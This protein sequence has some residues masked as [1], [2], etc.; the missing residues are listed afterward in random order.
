M[1]AKLLSEHR[2]SLFGLASIGVILVHSNAVIEWPVAI[3]G[4]LFGFGGIGVYVFA[5]LSGIGLF[6]SM[7]KSSGG[8][9]AFYKR[10]LLRV[11]VPYFIIAGIWYGIKYLVLEPSFVGF[12]WELSTLSYW[13]EHKGAWYVAMLIPLYFFYPLFYKWVESGERE[14]KMCII[15]GFLLIISAML[16]IFCKPVYSH[17]SQVINSYIVFIVGHY[18]GE[19]VM[20][21]KKIPV[22]LIGFSILFYPIRAMLPGVKNISLIGSISYA[23][24]GVA[25]SIIAAFILTKLPQWV[26]NCLDK[27]GLIS[28]EL[29]LTNI[30]LI[31]AIQLMNNL[32]LIKSWYG[33]LI[34]YFMTVIIGAVMSCLARYVN[35]LVMQKMQIKRSMYR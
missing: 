8:D 30:F 28:L 17:L 7:K 27:V 9:R 11:V 19:K 10:R 3:V 34:L 33:W 1:D 2:N 15:I 29:Y 22:F 21:G 35:Q 25:F 4:K 24:L 5:F 16:Y 31:Q 13:F 18:M 14:R 6:F 20:N 12:I 23:M 26:K 32:I